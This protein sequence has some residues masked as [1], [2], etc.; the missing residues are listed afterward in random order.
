[1]SGKVLQDQY[2]YPSVKAQRNY[3]HMVLHTAR[4]NFEHRRRLDW[5]FVSMLPSFNYTVQHT[6]REKNGEQYHVGDDSGLSE[7][8]VYTS[9]M[10]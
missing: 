3:V 1:M 2:I 10:L 6:W 9:V 8:S 7:A 5:T 4:H